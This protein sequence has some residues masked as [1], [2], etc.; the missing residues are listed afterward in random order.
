MTAT[1]PLG[2]PA[3]AAGLE[4]DDVIVAVAGAN[5]GSAIE[6]EQLVRQR[7]PGDEVP[8]IFERRGQRITG[9]LRLV[10]DPRIEVVPA[11]AAGR[12]LSAEQRNLR[13]AWLSSAARN[14][15]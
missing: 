13:D 10:A 5:V 8:V 14:T 12:S 15:F 1:V 2:S 6:F 4:R 11:E 7:K 3:Y 9:R